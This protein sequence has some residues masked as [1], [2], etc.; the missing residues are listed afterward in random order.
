MSLRSLLLSSVAAFAVLGSAHATTFGLQNSMGDSPTFSVTSN[1]VTA[2]YS[3][4]TGNGFQVQDTTG[5][6]TFSTALLDN[7]FFGSDPLTITFSSA[8][9][10]TVYLPFAIL[11]SY[12]T[13]DLLVLTTNTGQSMSF[14][15]TPDGLAL[16]EPEGIATMLMNAPTQ[17]FTL[18]SNNA[19]AIGDITTA[20]APAATPEPGSIVLLATG[21]AGIALTMGRRRALSG[22]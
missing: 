21:L 5:L 11:D 7:N 19:F 18:T 1:G 10:G 17:S 16:G 8:V 9:S 22:M 4:P 2:T 13:N 6:L 12:G 20:A 14:G 3:S 15:A